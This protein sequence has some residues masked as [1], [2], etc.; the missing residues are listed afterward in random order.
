MTDE[1]EQLATKALDEVTQAGLESVPD[2]LHMLIAGAVYDFAGFLTTQEESLTVG[3]RENAC[4]VADLLR[5]WADKR[6]LRLKGASV[7]SWQD[8]LTVPAATERDPE[9][10][11]EAEVRRG[12][13]AR[14]T[15]GGA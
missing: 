11:R 9:L 1:Q 4:P 8:M 13:G 2:G 5:S 3:A 6:G 14:Q 12:L 7:L 10:L 15:G